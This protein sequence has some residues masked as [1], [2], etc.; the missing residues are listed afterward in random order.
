MI[1]AFPSVALAATILLGAA[2]V[3]AADTRTTVRPGIELLHRVTTNPAQDIVAVRV[4]L[5]LPQVGLHASAD[6]RGEEWAVTTPTFARNTGS[7]VAINADFSDITSSGAARLRPLGL[8][9]SDGAQWNSHIVDDT[10]GG[11]WGFFGCTVDKRCQANVERPLDQAFW[12]GDT[13]KKPYRFFQ[14]IGANGVPMV[15]GGR[16][17][18]GCYDTIRNPRSAIGVEADGTHLWLVVIDGRDPGRASGMTCDETR[19]LLLD[20]GVHDGVM[21][22]G[23]GSSTLVVDGAVKNQPSDGAPRTVG[24][25]LGITYQDAIDPRCE[26]PNARFCDGTVIATCQGGRFLG[27][28]DCGAF[29]AGCQEDGDFAFCVHPFCPGGDG[30]GASCLDATRL[31]SCNDGAL[32]EGDCGAFGL[33]CG[34]DDGHARCMDPRCAAG[35][36]G[37]FCTAGGALGTSTAGAYTESACDDGTACSGEAGDA[38]CT[39]PSSPPAPTPPADDANGDDT[40]GDDATGD[41]ATGDDANGDDANGDDANGDDTTGDDANGDDTNGDDAVDDEATGDGGDPAPPLP[42]AV[43]DGCRQSQSP[44]PAVLA[45]LLL[46]ARRWPRCRRAR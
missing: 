39:S 7:L 24:N 36:D 6:R 4:D 2:P 5:S 41:D 37:A 9:V 3:V 33:V 44:A 22:D 27:E 15:N 26:R 19:Q 13:T 8:A 30:F 10:I 21:L 40:N 34:G 16:A 42:R 11:T 32:G 23:G 12:F 17:H 45:A 14:A 43:D 28:G 25:H 46:L 38:R 18:R 29:G 31:S 35:P 1:R 20:L